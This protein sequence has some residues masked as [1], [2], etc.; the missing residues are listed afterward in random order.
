MYW[1][2]SIEA[3]NLFS[4]VRNIQDNW[5][6]LKREFVLVGELETLDYPSTDLAFAIAVKLLG[7]ESYTLP[8]SWFRMAH[9]KIDICQLPAAAPWHKQLVYDVNLQGMIIA[10]HQ[11]QY[12]VHYHDKDWEPM[13]V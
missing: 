12:P 4:T 3:Q 10:G 1:R 8:L 11:Q 2:K 9:M 13:D 7:E 6:E 5:E